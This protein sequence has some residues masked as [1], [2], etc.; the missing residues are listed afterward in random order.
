M[1]TLSRLL[2]LA[3]ERRDAL[4]AP[5]APILL[6]DREVDSDTHPVV[7]GT[8]NLS[9]DSTYRDSIAT[10]TDSAV[11]RGLLLGAQGADLVDLLVLT[12]LSSSRGD[13]RRS[14]DQRG[15]S[16]NNR[17]VDSGFTPSDGDLLGGRALLLRKGK[18]TYHHVAVEPA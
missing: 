9:R 3:E 13:A 10:S 11:R 8:V 12:G 6:G 4:D 7:M 18:S 5:V 2:G 17:K 14:L 1:I 15:I 16:V